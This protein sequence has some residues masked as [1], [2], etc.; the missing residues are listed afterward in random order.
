MI[1]WGNSPRL[2]VVMLTMLPL[3]ASAQDRPLYLDPTQPIEKRIDDLLARLTLEEKVSF[4]HANSIFAIA[5]VERLKIPE[6]MMADGPMGVREDVGNGF[7]VLNRTDDYATAFPAPIAMAA[8]WDIDLAKSMG[9]AIGHEAMARGKHIMLN[10]AINIMRTPL[11]GRNFEYF[12]EDPY[13]IG[14]LAV[15]FILGEQSEG[16]AACVKHFAVNNQETQRGTINVELDERTLREIYLPAFEAA[17]KEAGAL[18]IM[19]AYNKVRGAYC[20]ENDFLLNKVLKGEWGFKGIVVSDWGAT[21]TTDGAAL[22]GLDAEMGTRPPYESNFL[23]A[24][25]LEGLKSGKY[26]MSVLDDKVRRHL[27]VMFKLKLLDPPPA[28]RGGSINTREHQ[29]VACTVAEQGMVL[30]KNEGN[31]LPL[32]SNLEN[33]NSI[34]VIGDHA[35]QKYAHSGFGATVKSF[36]EVTSLEGIVNRVGNRATVTYSAAYAPPAGRG[37]R[38]GRGPATA[39][40]QNTALLDRAVAAAKSADVVIFVAG[41]GHIP[42]GDDEST[43][44]RDMKLLGNQD[45]AIAKILA[46][47]PRTIIVLNAGS[48]VEMPWL[49]QAPT[50]L[51]A[52]YGGMEAGNALARV[53]LGDVNP[54]G[55]LPYSSP[56]QLS[57]SPA[58]ALNAFPGT[59]GVLKYEEGLLVGYRWFDAKNIEPLFPFGHG[60]SYTKFDYSNL[61]VTTGTDGAPAMVEFDITN[62]GQRDGAEVTQVY[63]QDVQSTLP[64]PARELKGFRKVMLRAGQKQTISISLPPRSFAYYD[65]DKA[66]WVAEAG[67]FVIHVGSSSR[68]IRLKG[69][70]NLATTLTQVN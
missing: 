42:G 11:C 30:L 62:T 67:E 54:S 50:V 63:V 40:E 22:G 55:K 15:N 19:G 25:F 59:N 3:I 68:D 38:R 29:T 69:N 52:W 53:L 10:P 8:T 45:E 37:G 24:P 57:D 17:V 6:L 9:Q 34:A 51:Q 20:C 39:P 58:H 12:G 60:L 31:L 27:H 43:D 18:S 5:G 47:N 21:H 35:I 61:K 36:Y 1:R 4:C 66:A 65:P 32:P 2:L 33:I 49:A 64:R 56:K 70:F 48:P 44:R 23:G 16:V 7:R 28:E 26:P 46:A 41:L 13:L 14:K